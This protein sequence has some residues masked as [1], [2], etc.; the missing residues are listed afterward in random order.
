MASTLIHLTVAN[1]LNKKLGKDKAKFLI[2]SIAPD[3]SK[4]VGENKIRSHFLVNDY[5]SIPDLD[6]FL[7]K[8]NYFLN[9]DF[10]LG[11][12]VH[13]Y[14]DYLWF[15]I[16]LPNIY[17]EDKHLIKKLNGDVVKCNGNMLSMYIY[18]DYTNMN[19]V[20][21]DKYNLDLSL[22]YMPL[23]EFRCLIDEIPMDQLKLILDKTV[24]IINDVKNRKEYTFDEEMM[25]SFIKFSVDIIE[26]NLKD[27]RIIRD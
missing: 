6:K 25:D 15:K 12:Y 16:F 8:Y 10:V 5:D 1:E 23:P 2:G 14:T 18:N 21:I 3:L 26:N 17:N 19:S 27:L 11:Y 20:L 13:L 9:D 7:N 24:S 4:L 22:F